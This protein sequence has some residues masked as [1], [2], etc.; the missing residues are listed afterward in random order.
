MTLPETIHF[1]VG[2]STANESNVASNQDADGDEESAG[3]PSNHD[4]LYND[5]YTN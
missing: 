5:K 4:T 2:H 1:N 3:K